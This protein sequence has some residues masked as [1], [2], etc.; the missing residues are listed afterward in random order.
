MS[1]GVPAEDTMEGTVESMWRRVGVTWQ[2]AGVVWRCEDVA[3]RAVGVAWR[4]VEA[5]RVY[6][7]HV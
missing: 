5:D 7:K 4:R 2:R 1:V 6:S 3:W